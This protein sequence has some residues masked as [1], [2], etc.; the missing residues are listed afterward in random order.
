MIV[1]S[2]FLGG[3]AISQLLMYITVMSK[4]MIKVDSYF[5]MCLMSNELKVILKY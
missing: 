3:G 2:N 1:H 5:N 4:I